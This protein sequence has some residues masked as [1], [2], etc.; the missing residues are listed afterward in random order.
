MS[1]IS[2]SFEELNSS[3]EKLA[4]NL[5][6]IDVKNKKASISA[7]DMANSY[8]K[9]FQEVME[10]IVLQM[11][12]IGA[13]IT[14]LN[15]HVG[16]A[17]DKNIEAGEKFA[18]KIEQ[19][20]KSSMETIKLQ[21]ESASSILESWISKITDKT[22]E[23]SAKFSQQVSTN[24]TLLEETY[25]QINKKYDDS[26][27]GLFNL[28]AHKNN[29]EGHINE[30]KKYKSELETAR[31]HTSV[32]YDLM[33]SHYGKDSEEFKKVQEEKETALDTLANKVK[34]V[35]IQI[36][37]S[38]NSYLDIWN[39]QHGAIKNI[40]DKQKA[41]IDSGTKGF[42]DFVAN[43]SAGVNV[44]EENIS[45]I[46]DEEKK[47]NESKYK[48]K[49][50]K[51]DKELNEVRKEVIQ[52]EKEKTQL[53]KE[54]S[55]AQKLA[56][57]YKDDIKKIEK[58]FG[59][60]AE[61]TSE[62]TNI[63]SL[64]TSVENINSESPENGMKNQDDLSQ[65]GTISD[66]EREAAQERLEELRKMAEEQEGIVADK[67]AAIE[68]SNQDIVESERSVLLEQMRI[69]DE[70]TKLTEDKIKK[71]EEIEAKA[72]KKKDKL[73]K[74]K[75]IKEKAEF[76][77]NIAKAV[78]D[79]A[80]GVANAWSLGPFIGPPMAALVA[81]QGAIQIKTMTQQLKYMEDGGLLKGK[82]HHA[83]GMRIEG[84]NIE[85]EGG[86]YVVNRQSTAKNMSLLRYINE[87]RRELGSADI[88]NFFSKS[89]PHT[90]RLIQQ[91]MLENGGQVPMLPMFDNTESQ[92]L[93]A[94][95][96]INFQPRVA[97]TDINRV[98]QQMADVDSWVG[99]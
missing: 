18:E 25:D 22:E 24:K 15:T 79:V 10:Y 88:H 62:L 92:I 89:I 17:I 78:G 47:L 86:E 99:M 51:L 14:E 8:K 82:R 96:K 42:Q 39:K 48:K 83:G 44:I 41:N 38:N 36:Q 87:E 60:S 29:V 72:Q 76:V 55:E 67:Q 97:V 19:S 77:V 54:Q 9:E 81:L 35:N 6:K 13:I 11:S 70:K 56:D 85:V 53:E 23:Q 73:E 40:L 65:V 3:T 21:A 95:E 59:E 5:D 20:S 46:S 93:R 33:A 61:S 64:E 31:L 37:E 58:Y 16:K 66:E 75:K 30:L 4:E 34:E 84:T 2:K 49:S 91:N 7:K 90:P 1:K 32:Q 43:F 26:E 12:K 57:K 94:I 27:I 63:D 69:E 98:Q 68:K 52:K 45:K 74:I 50:E 28:R 80:K 71:D